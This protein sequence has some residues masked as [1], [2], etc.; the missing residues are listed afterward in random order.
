MPVILAE[1]DFEP[2]LRRE[3]GLELLKPAPK[4]TLQR[5]RVSKRVNSSKAP[6]D[7]ATLMS[8]FR[9]NC[10]TF[11]RHTGSD[12]AP[13][14]RSQGVID[15]ASAAAESRGRRRRYCGAAIARRMVLMLEDSRIP[16]RVMPRRFVDHC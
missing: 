5:W 9:C 4:D 1:K 13:A 14:G 12:A 7:D 16:A 15:V 11:R 2:W 3:A 10:L 8:K 6:G